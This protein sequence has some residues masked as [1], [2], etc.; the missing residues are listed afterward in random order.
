MTIKQLAEEHAPV[1]RGDDWLR[2][3]AQI[4]AQTSFES[5]AKKILEIIQSAI[6]NNDDI[7]TIIN[8]L[9]DYD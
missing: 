4:I 1:I 9:T 5:G 3:K 8:E 6:D 7:R 2:V